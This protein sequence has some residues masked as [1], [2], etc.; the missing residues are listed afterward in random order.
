MNNH[1]EV[2]V[3]VATYNG[4]RYLSKQ[5]DSILQQTVKPRKIRILD[6]CSRDSTLQIAEEYKKKYPNTILIT[7]NTSNLGVIRNF[8]KGIASCQPGSYIA[9]A[10]QDD[11]WFPHK[12]EKQL[13]TIASSPS[14]V[15][16]ICYSDLQTINEDDKPI[17]SSFWYQLG[18]DK[19]KHTFQTLLFG[20]FVTGCTIL[21]NEKMK[22]YVQRIPDDNDL[23]DYWIAL[24]SFSLGQAHSISTPLVSYRQ[25]ESNVTY[26]KGIKRKSLLIRSI[27]HLKNLLWKNDFL[28]NRIESV[29][30]FNDIFHS[31]IPDS[32]RKMLVK[33]VA[34]SGSSYLRK[35]IFMRK[36]FKGFW[37]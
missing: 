12:L 22:S 10:D 3:V 29:R 21:M 18:V 36:A 19:Y 35:K 5:L 16:T 25:H 9:L 8:K 14:E 37:V 33:F 26:Y 7:Q 4:D 11:V 27:I 28:E 23:H 20:N 34:L 24:I 31:E 1:P 13:A 17:H 15:P 2:E 30:L 6:D 32:K